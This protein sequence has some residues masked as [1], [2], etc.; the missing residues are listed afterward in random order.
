MRRRPLA[1][2]SGLPARLQGRSRS[3]ASRWYRRGLPVVV[4]RG[5]IMF[6]RL[7]PRNIMIGDDARQDLRDDQVYLTAV[8]TGLVDQIQIQIGPSQS[9]STDGVTVTVDD[10]IRALA[11]FGLKL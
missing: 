8:E 11:E 2:P 10:L 4:N 3:R 1:A 5:G 9:E 6:D 7:A